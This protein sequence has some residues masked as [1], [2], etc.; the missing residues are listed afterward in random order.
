MNIL[1]S[2]ENTIEFL[3]ETKSE[4]NSENFDSHFQYLENVYRKSRRDIDFMLQDKHSIQNQISSAFDDM[5]QNCRYLLH[6]IWIHSG[7][8]GSGHYWSFTLD[9]RTKTW[10]KFNDCNVTKVEEEQVM[11]DAVGGDDNLTS[12]Y[13]LI[14]IDPNDES[15]LSS[16]PGS[17][18]LDLIPISIR[19]EIEI[20]NVKL[21]SSIEEFSQQ[22]EPLNKLSKLVDAL[23]QKITGIE[24]MK[25]SYED[26][27]NPRLEYVY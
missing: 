15:L 7:T 23:K 5:K 18:D 8:S 12:A 17:V 9:H 16:L 27:A 14:Y 11:K 3:K 19:K 2:I 20:E 26:Y 10:F 25:F 24:P 6:S 1:R 21:M 22:N 4:E 13:F